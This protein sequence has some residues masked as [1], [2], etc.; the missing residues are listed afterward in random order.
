MWDAEPSIVINGSTYTGQVLAGASFTFGNPD[1]LANV[2]PPY[3][4][5]SIVNIFGSRLLIDLN[6]SVTVS[7][8]NAEKTAR[9]VLFTG[10]ITDI[11]VTLLPDNLPIYDLTVVGRSQRYESRIIGEL[12]FGEQYDATRFEDLVRAATGPA[13]DLIS[14][15][16]NGQT[17]S[18][19]G[20]GNLLGTATASPSTY[21]IVVPLP[22]Q[23]VNA[24]QAIADF[25]QATSG[26]VWE[27]RLGNLNFRPFDALSATSFTVPQGA[28]YLAGLQRVSTLTELYNDITIFPNEN[29]LIQLGDSTNRQDL[30]SAADY[31]T[32]SF[33]LT[34]QYYHGPGAPYR[35]E[36]QADY[37]LDVF[38]DNIE[39]LDSLALDVT[40]DAL[41]DA[42]RNNLIECDMTQT[43]NFTL[44]SDIF[45]GGTGS[46]Q[47]IGWQW[48]IA[49]KILDLN[50][51]LAKVA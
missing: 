32:R 39:Q 31:G 35:W 6:D 11:S 1:L 7:V 30:T 48:T 45:L 34:T 47:I 8:D 23:A 41:T 26:W 42:V 38:A 17:G 3:G 36:E 49:D 15:T 9:R 18:I 51:N 44:P 24:G 43:V 40:S 14:G 16:I 25:A 10:V 46:A 50:I 37:L 4:R 27:N 19:N 28:I 22:A 2:Q 5:I 13:I 12:G 33:S 29:D 21:A 20:Y